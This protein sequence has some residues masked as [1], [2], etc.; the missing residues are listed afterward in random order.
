MAL[1]LLVT[2]QD[3][4]RPILG[5]YPILESHFLAQL[6]TVHSMGKFVLDELGL[7]MQMEVVADQQPQK[8]LGIYELA[9]HFANSMLGS[10]ELLDQA[11]VIHQSLAVVERT[12]LEESESEL[13]D[14]LRPDYVPLFESESDDDVQAVQLRCPQ[15]QKL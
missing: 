15:L 14:D 5:S 12:Q 1:L 8:F 7:G 13:D 4:V 3:S 11:V 6:V 2:V 10:L 9:F